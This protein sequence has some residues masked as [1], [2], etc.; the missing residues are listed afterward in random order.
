MS[1][2]ISS[3]APLD[4]RMGAVRGMGRKARF[5]LFGAAVVILLIALIVTATLETGMYYLTVDEV[6]GRQAGLA[7]QRLRVNGAVLA[8]S[9]I[10]DA[11]AT[12]LE[13]QIHDVEGRHVLPVVY[14]GPRPD[15]FQRATS[16][17][18]EGSLSPDG[19]FMADELLLKCPSRYEEAES[20]LSA[21]QS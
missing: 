7:G 13:F 4:L 11:R 16:A 9:E 21:S 14:I 5:S 3:R 6:H 15:N 12:R 18:V 1:K 8:D 19:T 2:A 10:W 17:I 20:V